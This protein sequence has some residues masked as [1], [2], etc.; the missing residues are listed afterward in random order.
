MF[1]FTRIIVLFIDIMPKGH[2]PTHFNGEKDHYYDSNFTLDINERMRVPKN[3][4]ISGDY[5][6]DDVISNN[7]SSW[8]QMNNEKCDMSVPDRILVVGLYIL[9]IKQIF[10][11]TQRKSCVK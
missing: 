1:C 7:G 9:L 10:S 5:S 3:I 4:R 2:S 6:D 11:L 8:N